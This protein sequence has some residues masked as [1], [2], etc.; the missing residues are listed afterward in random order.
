MVCYVE[1]VPPKIAEQGKPPLNCTAL[2]SEKLRNVL[3]RL[4]F[5]GL[6]IWAFGTVEKG[7]MEIERTT[8]NQHAHIHHHCA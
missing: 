4:P 5:L 8:K 1:I 3:D 2:R 6:S 7:G